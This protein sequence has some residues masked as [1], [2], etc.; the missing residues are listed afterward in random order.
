MKKLFLEKGALKESDLS[1]FSKSHFWD[2][3]F[4]VF[5]VAITSQDSYL[6]FY[7]L[8]C[9][10]FFLKWTIKK[11]TLGKPVRYNK[12]IIQEVCNEKS[13]GHFL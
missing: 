10:N 11:L 8:N 2:Y 9:A 4:I 12:Y 7:S 13:S 3:I 5:H 1:G 6:S